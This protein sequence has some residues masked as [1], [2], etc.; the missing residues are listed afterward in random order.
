LVGEQLRRLTTAR[1]ALAIT[2]V[3]A[4]C[5][6]SARPASA[7]AV[8][9]SSS[10]AQVAVHFAA[11]PRTRADPSTTNLVPREIN[12]NTLAGGGPYDVGNVPPGT[13]ELEH[14]AD[15]KLTDGHLGAGAGA[16]AAYGATEPVLVARAGTVAPVT[17]AV[18][19]SARSGRRVAFVEIKLAP[20]PPV[21][22]AEA[23]HLDIGTDGGDGGFNAGAV[24]AATDD[25][26]AKGYLAAHSPKKHNGT[27]CVLRTVVS[28]GVTD[29]VLFSTG[30]GNGAY[31]TELGYD[32]SG[33]IVSL[34]SY[35]FVVPWRLSGLPGTPPKEVTDQA[36]KTGKSG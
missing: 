35:G 4:G 27:V 21:R 23:T 12:T 18:L 1:G 10:L 19:N 13:L 3:A 25:A 11:C 9:G 15:L 32:G 34:V 14:V 33:K 29:S 7:P 16:E 31:P 8:L 20:Q 17:L 30:Y 6:S 24:I 5:G 36:A 26:T 22:W 28:D 2:L